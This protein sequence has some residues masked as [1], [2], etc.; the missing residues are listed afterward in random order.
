MMSAAKKAKYASK[1]RVEWSRCGLKPSKKGATHAYCSLCQVDICVAGGGKADVDRHL[2]TAKHV[3]MLEQMEAQPSLF[4][5]TFQKYR[6]PSYK[7]RNL[8]YQVPCRA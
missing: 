5:F 4:T 3:N 6:G 7:S 2:K 8:F 1:Y